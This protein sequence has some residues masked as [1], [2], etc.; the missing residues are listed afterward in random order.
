MKI[1]KIP[2]K[3]SPFFWLTAA[4]IGWLSSM[5]MKQML[6]STLIWVGVIFV[7]V[8]VHEMGHALTALCFKRKSRIELVAFGGATYPEGPKLKGLKEFIM[9][10]NGPL[11]GF[12][13]FLLSS[14]FLKLSLFTSPIAL[15]TLMIFQW[16]NLFWT[17]ANLVPVM[18]LDGGQLLRIICESIA[19]A[20]GLNIAL[21]ISAVI[22]AVASFL[23]FLLGYFIIGA[24]FFL[25]AFQNFDAWRKTRIITESDQ[26]EEFTTELKEIE[27]LM[28]HDNKE[29]VLVRL[30][31]IRKRVKKGILFTITSQYLAAL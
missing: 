10:L 27:N 2:I 1:P 5:G 22:S 11:F 30:E 7:S 12:F 4:L 23:F 9:V 3:V 17:L 28:L 18:P 25:F 13:L 8:L 31:A 6:I 20:R 16:V 14:L 15:Y 19:G 21:L 26:K 24:L 29:E